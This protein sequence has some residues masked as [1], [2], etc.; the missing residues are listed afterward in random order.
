MNKAALYASIALLPVLAYAPLTQAGPESVAIDKIEKLETPPA[1]GDTLPLFRV[2]DAASK[3]EHDLAKLLEVGPV[4][5][6]FYRGSWCP[7]CVSELSTVQKHLEDI[8]SVGATVL[9]ISPEKPSE[10]ADLVGQK[11]FGFLFGTDQDNELATKLALSFKL[12]AKT[13]KRYKNYGI[14]LPESND[15][16]VWELPIPAT[17]IV[18]TDGTIAWSFVD[19]DYS[20]RPDYKKVVQKLRELQQD[21]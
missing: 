21:D 8:T 16:K 5:V 3:G 18:D 1:Q 15:A 12:D 10:T 19:E 13:I 9:A 2:G 6:T 20:K 7:Y 14:D 11:E 4:V 17:Y